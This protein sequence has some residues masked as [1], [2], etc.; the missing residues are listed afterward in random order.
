[1]HSLFQKRLRVASI[2][3]GECSQLVVRVFRLSVQFIQNLGRL[4]VLGTLLLLLLASI[5]CQGDDIGIYRIYVRDMPQKSSAPAINR[6]MGEM[7]GINVKAN[8]STRAQRR[9]ST[10]TQDE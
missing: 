2:R 1:M 7:T 5:G 6:A 10:R 4:I 8:W 9:M 3:D